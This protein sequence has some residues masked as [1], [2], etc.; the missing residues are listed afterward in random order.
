MNQ[1]SPAER[2]L[3]WAPELTGEALPVPP[4]APRGPGLGAWFLLPARL[5]WRQLRAEKARL[6]AA[7]AGVMFACVLVFMQLGFRGALFD[8]ATN[9]LTPCKPTS[10]SCTP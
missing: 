2:L 5:A 8:S 1:I 10:S 6:A 7:M 9:M 4:E 3:P